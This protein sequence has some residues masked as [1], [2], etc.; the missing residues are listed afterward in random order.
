MVCYR[1]QRHLWHSQ[2]RRIWLLA[3]VRRGSKLY[4]GDELVVDNDDLHAP[5]TEDGVKSPTPGGRRIRVLY[6]QGLEGPVAL[7][8]KVLR[9]GE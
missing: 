2:R 9:A 5:V 4:I 3:D 7:V 1:F 6:F 8:L